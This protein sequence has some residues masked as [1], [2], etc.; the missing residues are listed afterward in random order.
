MDLFS[1]N[2]DSAKWS[3][4]RVHCVIPAMDAGPGK[5][6]KVRNSQ[7]SSFSPSLDGAHYE[8]QLYHENLPF[9][10]PCPFLPEWFRLEKKKSIVLRA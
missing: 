5:V 9:S 7:S 10:N 4:R 6:Q 2:I 3:E 8:A 1:R